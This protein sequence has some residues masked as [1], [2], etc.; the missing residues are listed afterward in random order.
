M[1]KST[2]TQ[3]PVTRSDDAITRPRHINPV[4]WNEAVALARQACA[5]VFRNGGTPQEA[6]ATFGLAGDGMG[7]GD[8][9]KAVDR[10]A[11]SL[12]RTI[13]RAA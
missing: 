4:Q 2:P 1:I 9:S 11:L 13:R 6:L 3:S 5:R 10:A 12:C 8:W 7:L